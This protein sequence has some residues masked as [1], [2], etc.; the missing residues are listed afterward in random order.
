MARRWVSAS[1]FAIA[2]MVIM[3]PSSHAQKWY[4]KAVK[5]VE[6]RFTPAEAKPGQT[7]TFTLTVELHEGYHTYPLVQPDPAAEGMTNFIKF[8]APDNVIFVGE[9]LD[10]K[11]FA[12][13]ADP[14]LGI[15]EL[16]YYTGKVVYTRKAVVAPHA[17]AGETTIKLPN[18]SLNV[19]DKTTC[20][21][22]KTLTIEVPLK[23]LD[24]PA[25]AVEPAYADEVRQATRRP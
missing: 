25:V 24:G 5:K 19:C 17:R 23:I 3:A 7:V 4:E 9:T 16:R 10:P 15:K 18:F 6:G 14:A 22:P 1:V 21:P 2:V 20:F 8:P 12:T 13:K 11:D